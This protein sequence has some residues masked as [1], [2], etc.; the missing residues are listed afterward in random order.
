MTSITYWPVLLSSRL[1]VV[2]RVGRKGL[3]YK[4]IRSDCEFTKSTMVEIVPKETM[5]HAWEFIFKTKMSKLTILPFSNKNN[6]VLLMFYIFLSASQKM[7]HHHRITIW[8]WF[9]FYIVSCRITILL[10]II[11][12]ILSLHPNHHH[13]KIFIFH[14]LII[15]SLFQLPFY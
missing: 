8:W 12:Y 4:K 9:L 14:T 15:I 11:S 5:M 6:W 13:I 7:N 1:M 10:K 3:E 2:L